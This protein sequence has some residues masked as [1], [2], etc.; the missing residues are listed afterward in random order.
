DGFV[1]GEGAGMIVLEEYE[2]AKRRGA[3][4]YAEIRGYGLSGDAFHYTAPPDDGRGAARAMRRALEIGGLGIGDIDY[5]NA[6][7][8]S[9]PQGDLA[10]TRGIK[11]VFGELGAKDLKVSSTKGA[12]G[13]LLGAAGA[14]EAIFT[15]LA[16]YHD[17]IPPTLNLHNVD[18]P[19]EFSLDYVPLVARDMRTAGG[20]GVQ[21]GLSNS[22]GFGGT[23]CSL[24]FSK[25]K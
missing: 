6:H 7:A 12:I 21:A 22:F 23:N 4:I 2:H 3:N 18:P 5:I 25:V 1:I 11:S 19:E 10:E 17:V 9:T 14:V 16:I 13:H 15:I 8:T 20:R 24:A